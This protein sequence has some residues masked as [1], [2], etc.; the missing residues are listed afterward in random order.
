M[1]ARTPAG[2]FRTDLRAGPH[3]L[4]AD[5]PVAYGG[6]NLGPTPY[7]LL[8]AALASCTTMTLQMYARRKKLQLD[9][10]TA[11]VTHSKI[12]ASDCA[13]CDDTSDLCR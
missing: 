3:A 11:R 13:D 5:E 6:T 7:D 8:G 4:L 10:V 1:I 9:S 12:H 2:G